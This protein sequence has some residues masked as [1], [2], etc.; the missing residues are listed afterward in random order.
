MVCGLRFAVQLSAGVPYPISGPPSLPQSRREAKCIFPNLRLGVPDVLVLA[1]RSLL[2]GFWKASPS[3]A[4][5]RSRDQGSISGRCRIPVRVPAFTQ[6]E[7]EGSTHGRNGLFHALAHR[8]LHS[9]QPE[10]RTIQR[11]ER[12]HDNIDRR[13]RN[14]H[15]S[16]IPISPESAQSNSQS[17]SLAAGRL[18]SAGKMRAPFWHLH[19]FQRDLT[20]TKQSSFT[21]CLFVGQHIRS[22]PGVYLVR[23]SPGCLE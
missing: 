7:L 12:G 5:Q 23:L 17:S 9:I 10:A 2:E 22:S 4:L 11:P 8:Q 18:H 13:R 1:H 16:M 3:Q 20:A 19:N 21:K 15:P 6:G 14:L